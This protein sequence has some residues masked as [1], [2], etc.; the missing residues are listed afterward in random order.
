MQHQVVGYLLAILSAVEA[1]SVYYFRLSHLGLRLIH[2]LGTFAVYNKTV[3][4]QMDTNASSEVLKVPAKL[5]PQSRETVY[6]RFLQFFKTCLSPRFGL[7][8]PSLRMKTVTDSG[9]L[10]ALLTFNFACDHRIFPSERQRLDVAG[11]YLILAYTGCR[12]AEVVDGE[13]NIP[14]DGC[15]DELFGDQTTPPLEAVP[16]DT[17]GE[18]HFKEVS[19]LLDLEAQNRNRPKALCYEDIQLMVIRHPETG[20]DTLTMSIKFTHHKGADNRPKP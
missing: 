19:R 20:L 8:N 14:L 18:H 16:G 13:K 1:A 4:R 11:C 10:L 12:P 3:G 17:A 6:L 15:W 5:P 9:D 2:F 7:E